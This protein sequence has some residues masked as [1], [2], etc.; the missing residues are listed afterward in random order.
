VLNFADYWEYG[1]FLEVLEVVDAWEL[2]RKLVAEGLV[3]S[4]FDVRDLADL[5]S[6]EFKSDIHP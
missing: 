5:W 2:V 4:E 3:S 1:R 6:G